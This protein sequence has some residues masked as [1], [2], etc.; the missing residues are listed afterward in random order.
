MDCTIEEYLEDL[1]RHLIPNEDPRIIYWD[2]DFD[3]LLE[4]KDYFQKCLN[5]GFATY[6]ALL[7][8]E[9]YKKGRFHI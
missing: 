3:Y 5:R 6:W 4:Y 2:Y 1:K 8:F 9:D 7:F